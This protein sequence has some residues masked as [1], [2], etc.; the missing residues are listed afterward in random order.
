MT[1][2]GRNLFLSLTALPN[3]Q[4]STSDI[5]PFD[6]KITHIQVVVP[7]NTGDLTYGIM[8]N[9]EFI[10]PIDKLVKR[11][12]QGVDDSYIS[13]KVDEGDNITFIVN[14]ASLSASYDLSA[15]LDLEGNRIS[16]FTES[17]PKLGTPTLN[18]SSTATNV[19]PI[20]PRISPM[21]MPVYQPQQYVPMQNQSQQ[22]SNNGM[23]TT[24]IL[25]GVVLFAV[26][27]GSYITK[28]KSN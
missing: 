26:Y 12:I 7:D 10:Y 20:I 22:P 9:T 8:R 19:A 1:S 15:K 24:I 21:T 17:L 3:Q 28:C 13:T 6:G 25:I 11:P 5:I 16:S 2:I 4:T 27:I 18:V 23:L 14:N